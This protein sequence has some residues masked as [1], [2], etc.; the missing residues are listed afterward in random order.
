LKELSSRQV[1]K[2]KLVVWNIG[3]RTLAI[4]QSLDPSTAELQ[5]DLLDELDRVVSQHWSDHSFRPSSAYSTVLWSELQG[6]VA[7]LFSPHAHWT[8]SHTPGETSL[9]S[10][11]T[12]IFPDDWGFDF[13]SHAIYLGLHCYVDEK[14]S[15]DPSILKLRSGLPLLARELRLEQWY[16]KISSGFGRSGPKA[17]ML[18]VL[19]RCGAD[20][21]Q[22]FYGHPIWKYVVH[23]IHI[24]SQR[25]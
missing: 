10:L 21:N 7:N 14:L 15:R 1:F 11:R 9:F 3:D 18:G 5:V 2:D 12:F 19:L 25:F 22:L 13:L 6:K 8:N 4:A 24:A 16:M 20:P 17:E 23:Y